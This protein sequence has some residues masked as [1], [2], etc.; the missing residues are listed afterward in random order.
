MN[1]K[2]KIPHWQSTKALL[3]TLLAGILL[4]ALTMAVSPPT[5]F[6][7]SPCGDTVTV[8]AG[9]RSDLAVDRVDIVDGVA[10]ICLT[11]EL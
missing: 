1:K 5:A 6:A 2:T 8:V 9:Y 7:Q 4:V 11:G 3:H 10:S